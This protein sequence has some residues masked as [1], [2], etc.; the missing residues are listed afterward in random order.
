MNKKICGADKD[1][2]YN[3]PTFEDIAKDCPC[4]N[5]WGKRQTCFI[6]DFGNYCN[7]KNCVFWYWRNK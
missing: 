7:E 4:R 3:C 2:K 1:A 5:E 6:N